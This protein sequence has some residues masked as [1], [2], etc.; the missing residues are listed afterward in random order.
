MMYK[1]NVQ[2]KSLYWGE[3]S[4]IAQSE[5]AR[6]ESQAS[7]LEE[8]I[9][10]VTERG[11]LLDKDK[12]HPSGEAEETEDKDVVLLKKRITSNLEK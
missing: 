7:F 2:T 11:G 12:E 3:A 5:S 10:D 9:G 1:S 8:T 4:S 6:I